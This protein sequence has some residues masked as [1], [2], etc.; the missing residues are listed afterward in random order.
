MIPLRHAAACIVALAIL[1]PAAAE[2]VAELVSRLDTARLKGGVPAFA[3]VLVEQGQPAVVRHAGVADLD[4]RSPVSE[5]TRFRIGSI[6]KTFT[7]I[8][9]LLADRTGSLDIEAPLTEATG[10]G[11]VDIP[12]LGPVDFFRAVNVVRT[13]QAANGEVR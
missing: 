6:T 3:V 12:G 11:L 2:P 8:A 5:R 10:S 4:D 1:T 7:A 9:M 13:G